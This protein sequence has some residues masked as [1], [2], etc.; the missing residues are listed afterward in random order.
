MMKSKDLFHYDKDRTA[1]QLMNVKQ[2]F[3]DG[4]WPNIDA[5]L[6][7]M[8]TMPVLIVGMPRSGASVL[9]SM[10][11]AHGQIYGLGDESVVT[12]A[13]PEFRDDVL[14]ELSKGKEQMSKRRLGAVV[15]RHGSRILNTMKESYKN[16][17]S[18]GT[19]KKSAVK[20]VVDKS[21]TL[22]RTLGLVHFLFPKALILNMNRDPMDTLFSCYKNSICDN[23]TTTWTIDQE[24]MATE[25]LQHLELMDHFRTI[26][27]ENIIDISY[28]A[29]VTNPKESLRPVLDRLGLAWDDKMLQFHKQPRRV[30]LNSRNQVT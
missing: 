13:L 15:D 7:L 25:Y 8:S 30:K 18:I 22:Y 28:E 9:E 1:N 5:N 2:V 27:P 19:S 24:Y 4:S 26:I 21:L 16:D 12:S 20:Y 11:A 14:E 29:L 23:E 10:L 3:K 17:T 6:G